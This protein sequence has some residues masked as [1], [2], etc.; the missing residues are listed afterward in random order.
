MVV[1][2]GSRGIGFAIARALANEGAA[3]ALAARTQE[4][5]DDA[6]GLLRGEG[7]RCIAHRTDVS[8]TREV[9]AFFQRIRSEF[10]AVHVLVNNAGVNGAIGELTSC[11]PV[12]WRR[13]IEVNLLGTVYCT[14][15]AI[16]LMREQRGG[17]IINLAGGGVGGSAVAPRV[18]AYV[19]SK[20]AI[21]QFTEAIARELAADGIQ[22]NAVSP[23][24][25]ATEM[26]AA[27]VAAGPE[28]A[29][30]ELYER[31]LRQRAQGETPDLAARLVVWLASE[32]SGTLTGKLLSAKW[33]DVGQ[34]DPTAA[35]KSSLYTMRRIDGVLFREVD[36]R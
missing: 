1:T 18:S 19:T 11:D 10:G 31:T 13:A 34:L 33:D 20:A 2:G 25:V 32:R 14:R 9:E 7:A 30:A 12:E 5:L 23:G 28:K 29:G 3:L 36:E 26:T 35:N 15:A 24:A 4:Q 8:D 6:C 17:K 21:V 22:V 16:P 27:V